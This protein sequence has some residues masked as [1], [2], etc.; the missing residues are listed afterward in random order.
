M[1]RIDDD[2]QGCKSQSVLLCDFRRGTG[3]HVNCGGTC[4]LPQRFLLKD[5]HDRCVGGEDW[6][7]NGMFEGISQRLRPARVCK[8]ASLRS[9]NRTGDDDVPRLQRR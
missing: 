1:S 9:D 8:K 7:G 5:S 4:A 2:S 3:F 6:A